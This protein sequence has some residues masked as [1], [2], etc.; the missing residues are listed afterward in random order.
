MLPAQARPTCPDC[1]S[2]LLSIPGGY[3]CRGRSC[4]WQVGGTHDY[5]AAVKGGY[6]N[7]TDLPLDTVA[8]LKARRRL[9][10]AVLEARWRKPTPDSLEVFSK[11]A[12]KLNMQP[13]HLRQFAVVMSRKTLLELQAAVYVLNPEAKI[14]TMPDDEQLVIP[15]FTNPFSVGKLAIGCEG[16]MAWFA[17]ETRACTAGVQSYDPADTREIL[18]AADAAVASSLLEE[19]G[20]ARVL[21]L[22][23]GTEA[24]LPPGR[25]TVVVNRPCHMK[26]ASVACSI[27]PE[28]SVGI[29]DRGVLRKSRYLYSDALVAALTHAFS[30]G[31]CDGLEEVLAGAHVPDETLAKLSL[32]SLWENKQARETVTSRA[33]NGVGLKVEETPAGFK[34]HGQ[35]VTN[36]TLHPKRWRTTE[37]RGKM[38]ECE[39]RLGG[40]TD[41]IEIPAQALRSAPVFLKACDA[42]SV[43][44]RGLVVLDRRPLD[45]LLSWLLVKAAPLPVVHQML[46]IGRD[47]NGYHLPG[48]GIGVDGDFDSAVCAGDRY[49]A[50][51]RGETTV[52]GADLH[53]LLILGAML[54]RHAGGYELVSVGLEPSPEHEGALQRV[55]TWLGQ[56]RPLNPRFGEPQTVVVATPEYDLRNIA[57]QLKRGGAV[58]TASNDAVVVDT[59]R[60]LTG[61]ARRG[62]SAS[63]KPVRKCQ[64]SLESL[65]AEGAALMDAI[66]PDKLPVR[67]DL[68]DM[69]M[70]CRLLKRVGDATD[71]AFK[72]DLGRQAVAVDTQAFDCAPAPILKELRRRDACCMTDGRLIFIPDGTLRSLLL[73]YH[74]RH[75]PVG[76]GAL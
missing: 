65:T 38:L 31:G 58:L 3:Q 15:F 54:A 7:L 27:H 2:P 24:S 10:T 20:D 14:R 56:R 16:G 19:S 8:A 70:T 72:F 66:F 21:I 43:D 45:T 37:A 36:F 26:A 39:V 11:A 9:L 47:K 32:T 62:L 1:G 74:R 5:L 51:A 73:V 33:G 55:M 71:A 34:V 41:R 67:L 69:P 18:L 17:D 40:A 76:K 53:M 22:Y 12:Y 60:Y 49:G 48:V 25:K 59:F 63:F 50:M 52:R 35:L 13:E 64:P 42:E 57:I 68:T 29:L 46:W 23:P 4:R 61:C 75:M 28:V 6:D 44:G 30:S